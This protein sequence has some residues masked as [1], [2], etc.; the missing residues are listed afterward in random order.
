MV[1][2]VDYGIS[3]SGNVMESEDAFWNNMFKKELPKYKAR[4]DIIFSCHPF[5]TIN[6]NTTSKHVFSHLQK[7]PINIT[8]VVDL[9]LILAWEYQWEETRLSLF[10]YGRLISFDKL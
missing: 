7:C 2:V 8:F 10:H 5:E 3:G 6:I 9:N 4:L 1:Q